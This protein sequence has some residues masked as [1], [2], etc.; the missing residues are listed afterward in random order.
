M[1]VVWELPRI[2]AVEHNE[3]GMGAAFRRV[4]VTEIQDKAYVYEIPT[5]VVDGQAVQETHRLLHP[6][7]AVGRWSAPPH[8][9][10]FNAYQVLTGAGGDTL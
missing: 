5:S 6:L 8:H 4:S 7:G 9:I 10:R 2:L 3:C 1:A